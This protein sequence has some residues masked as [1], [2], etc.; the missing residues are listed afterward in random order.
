M[1]AYLGGKVDRESEETVTAILSSL[2]SHIIQLQ[3]LPNSFEEF[4]RK[5]I[6]DSG[7]HGPVRLVQSDAALRQVDFGIVMVVAVWSMPCRV[8]CLARLRILNE[9][10]AEGVPLI[11]VDNDSIS[12]DLFC[13]LFGRVQEGYCET[14]WI[15]NNAPVAAI[16]RPTNGEGQ[17]L[18]ENT[19]QL[20][21]C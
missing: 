19:R 6:R 7:W 2:E 17:I 14:F 20:L 15:R 4:C 5:A 1:G 12:P 10:G 21:T 8:P 16:W 11:L 13:E 18:E 9:I 3:P